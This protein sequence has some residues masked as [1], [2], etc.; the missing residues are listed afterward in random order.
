MQV[1]VAQHH[2]DVVAVGI[3]PPQHINIARAAVDQIAHAP[4]AVFVGI[5]L[6]PLQ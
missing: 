1:M 6:H 4:E 5:K 2:G 3:E